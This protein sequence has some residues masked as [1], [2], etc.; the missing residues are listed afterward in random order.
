MLEETLLAD[1]ALIKA[2]R[3]DKAGNLQFNKTAR[4]FNPEMCKA[5]KHVIVEVEE[6]LEDSYIDPNDVHLPG[7]FVDSIVVGD[8]KKKPVERLTNSVNT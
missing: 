2:I 4:N 8:I 6:Y 1:V 5:A 3:A 7:I